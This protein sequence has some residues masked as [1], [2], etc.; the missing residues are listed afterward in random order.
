MHVMVVKRKG[1]RTAALRRSRSR[2]ECTS[3][4][5][6]MPPKGSV[7]ANNCNSA[8]KRNSWRLPKSRLRLKTAFGQEQQ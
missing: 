1:E 2:D 5:A 7:N 4:T 6:R 8:Y 3:K